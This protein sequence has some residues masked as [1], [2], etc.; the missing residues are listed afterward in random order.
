MVAVSVTVG[1]GVS[2]GVSVIVAVLL[3]VGVRVGVAVAVFVAVRVGVWVLVAVAVVVGVLVGVFLAASASPGAIT[4]RRTA[5][6]AEATMPTL[7]SSGLCV[8][9]SPRRCRSSEVTG[10]VLIRSRSYR[11]EMKVAPSAVRSPSEAR[12]V[13]VS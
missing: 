4:L 2:V 6:R 10:R 8:T 1:V 3:G 9:I 5:Q 11:L 12:I 7:R 13:I